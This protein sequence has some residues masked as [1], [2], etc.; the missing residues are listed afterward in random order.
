MGFNGLLKWVDLELTATGPGSVTFAERGKQLDVIKEA[1]ADKDG[2]FE[3]NE[4]KA[5]C[6]CVEGNVCGTKN[7]CFATIRQLVDLGLAGTDFK[8]HNLSMDTRV[9]IAG[10]REEVAAADRRCKGIAD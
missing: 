5:T 2:V 9:N 7:N 4:D 10:R 1:L 8:K 3:H 6:S